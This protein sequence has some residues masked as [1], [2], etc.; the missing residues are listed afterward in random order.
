[1]SSLVNI[2][3]HSIDR[4]DWTAIAHQL[5]EEGYALLPNL[6]TTEQI[7]T[8]TA[9][10]DQPDAGRNLS[11]SALELGQGELLQLNEPLPVFLSTWCARFYSYLAPIANRWQAVLDLAYRYPPEWY[12]F[13]QQNQ[14]AGQT[15]SQSHLSHL[16]TSDYL[17]LHQHNN[18]EL[19]FPLQ[20]IAL[21]TEPGQD[22][23]GGEFIMTEQR[24]RRQSRPM[25]LPLKRGGVAIISTAQRPIK[26]NKGYYRANLKHAISRVR[27]DQRDG[28]T[29]L[30]HH[31]PQPQADQSI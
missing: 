26:G 18:G 15:Q 7:E 14:Q 28:L 5:D 1:M 17:T 20:V 19:I 8:L 6:L 12:L 29:L 30:F 10:F 24:P 31:A 25:V 3:T 4:L 23:Q 22:F 27:A 16:Q 21:L 9:L 11:L 13:L 2:F